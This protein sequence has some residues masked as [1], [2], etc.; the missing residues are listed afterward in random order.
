MPRAATAIIAIACSASYLSGD[1]GS[2]PVHGVRCVPKSKRGRALSKGSALEQHF[3]S[4]YAATDEPADDEQD[5]LVL[6]RLASESPGQH[7]WSTAKNNIQPISDVDT[8][9][10]ALRDIDGIAAKMALTA[11]ALTSKR[12]IDSKS[13]LARLPCTSFGLKVRGAAAVP[14]FSSLPE[15]FLLHTLA[16]VGPSGRAVCRAGRHC[17]DSSVEGAGAVPTFP[18]RVCVK[19]HCYFGPQPVT[20]TWQIDVIA[21]SAPGSVHF[22]VDSGSGEEGNGMKAQPEQSG[23]H[24][25]RLCRELRELQTTLGVHYKENGRM[26]VEVAAKD[27]TGRTL[28]DHTYEHRIF[29][30]KADDLLELLTESDSALSRPDLSGLTSGNNA[31]RSRSYLGIQ[32]CGNACAQGRRARPA[33]L[34][35]EGSR[36]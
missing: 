12:G 16:Y 29:C 6:A 17:F 31:P 18:V 9:S 33:S 34:A 25:L 5:E 27:A 7:S 4:R 36:V 24:I 1:T 35:R 11:L 8:D 28:L 21:P 20:T 32:G 22:S 2:V 14:A 23:G 26:Q 13:L 3:T 15:E 19:Q 30:S 10:K